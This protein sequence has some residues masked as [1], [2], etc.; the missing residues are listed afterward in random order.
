MLI[1]TAWT[2]M[3]HSSISNSW[4]TSRVVWTGHGVRALVHMHRRRG[5]TPRVAQPDGLSP[6]RLT[7][8]PGWLIAC[9][10]LYLE[11]ISRESRLSSNRYPVITRGSAVHKW[12]SRSSSDSYF[13]FSWEI[14]PLRQPIRSI[15]KQCKWGRWQTEVLLV[16]P[17]E[18]EDDINA[19]RKSNERILITGCS[20]SRSNPQKPVS[21]VWR[22]AAVWA[23]RSVRSLRIFGVFLPD[24]W[25]LHSFSVPVT[26]SGSL[27]LV[28][29]VIKPPC[30][31][32]K[33]IKCY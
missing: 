26:G 30:Y 14:T 4:T 33:M 32:S 8:G 12:R 5:Q 27:G 10:G 24:V 31:Q 19:K 15:C 2:L 6:R 16:P 20:V 22:W 17:E 25:S 11:T 28:I 18:E 23:L 29:L 21:R 7:F 3:T 9:F 1:R 13:L